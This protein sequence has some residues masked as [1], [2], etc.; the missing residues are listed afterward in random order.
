[1]KAWHWVSLRKNSNNDL[2]TTMTFSL[3]RMM[4]IKRDSNL[5]SFMLK[6]KRRVLS[7]VNSRHVTW[8]TISMIKYLPSSQGHRNQTINGQLTILDSSSSQSSLSLIHQ[9]SIFKLCSTIRRRRRILS[10]SSSNNSFNANT[11][12]IAMVVFSSLTTNSVAR[13]IWPGLPKKVKSM[14]LMFKMF[15]RL[16]RDDSKWGPHDL[17]LMLF[18]IMSTW[19]T[20]VDPHDSRIDLSNLFASQLISSQC[21]RIN[22]SHQT[23]MI[24]KTACQITV[25][26]SNL[27]KNPFSKITTIDRMQ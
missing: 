12:S 11:P 14:L 26:T 1:M 5:Q 3:L 23:T 13:K 15:A 16:R 25:I 9:M 10:S 22:T 18:K 24:V 27:S 2:L 8:L 19:R 20:R 7:K 6:F 17:N 21:M 4:M